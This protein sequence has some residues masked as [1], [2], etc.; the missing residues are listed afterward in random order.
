[1]TPKEK[2]E[3]LKELEDIYLKKVS[4]LAKEYRM[5]VRDIFGRI[6]KKKMETL[7]KELG[8]FQ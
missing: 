3:K 2:R 8:I 1:M 6:E 5:K 7:R 4:T